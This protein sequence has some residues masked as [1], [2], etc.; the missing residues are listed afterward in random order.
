MSKPATA[1][2]PELVSL[3]RDE[4]FVFL[5]TLNAETKKPHLSV[6]SWIWADEDGK[7]IKIAVGHKGTTLNNIQADPHVVIGTIGPDICYS[8]TGKAS[9][10]DVFERT[11]KFRII[12]VEVEEVE[13]I[14]FYGGKLTTLPAY[15]KTYNADLAKKLDDEVAELFLNT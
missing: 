10:S 3:L 8:I 13:D 11:M 5:T 6:V 15:V 7:R 2:S 12:T 4:S 9:V 14:M 1:L